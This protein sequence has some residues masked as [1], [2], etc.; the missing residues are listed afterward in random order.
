[1]RWGCTVKTASLLFEN[2]LK[3]ESPKIRAQVVVITEFTILI[4]SEVKKRQPLL[5]IEIV[6]LKK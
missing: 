5:S 6:I 2:E 1:M 4:V 3:S